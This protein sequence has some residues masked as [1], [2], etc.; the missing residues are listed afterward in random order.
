LTALSI[1]RLLPTP[2]AQVTGG[3]IF[4]R[5]SRE[6]SG[7]VPQSQT[8]LLEVDSATLR[9]IRGNRIAMVFQEPM[10]S[11]NPVLS[12]GD[13]IG[14]AILLHS[15]VSR[16]EARNRAVELLGKVGIPDASRRA[17][18]YPHRFSGGMRQ[19]AMTAMAL[20]NQPSLLVADEPTTALDVTTQA[21]ILDLLA[22]LQEENGMGVLLITHD[23]G[24]V[25]QWA[26]LVYVMYAGRIVEHAPARGL[27][28]NPLHPYTR[29]LLACTRRLGRSNERLPT[30]PGVVPQPARYPS[31]CRF[32]P[33]CTLTAANAT[34]QNRTT[35]E[36]LDG[37]RTLRRCA[38]LYPEEPSGAPPLEPRTGD[39]F[40]A[41]WEVG[42]D[43]AST[44]SP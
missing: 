9:S 21:Q 38:D 2:P 7:D 18:D 4:F 24:V 10:T 28:S 26:D 1:L 13:Q 22:R 36:L 23:L 41:C 44:A 39:H 17:S 27:L 5:D 43:V 3:R 6:N 31:G 25:G 34:L 35:I 37:R 14:E 12:I 11:L 16:R 42:C 40:V 15:P 19:R 32:H 20:A 30:I 33:R 29:G 8:N